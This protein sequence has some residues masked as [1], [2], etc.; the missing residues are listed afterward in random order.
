MSLARG[1]HAACMSRVN[2]LLKHKLGISS[3]N[4]RKPASFESIN[5]SLWTSRGCA[6]SVRKVKT[7]LEG[8]PEIHIQHLMYVMVSFKLIVT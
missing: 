3:L 2:V 6:K 1:M 5:S 7:F 4:L 8:D